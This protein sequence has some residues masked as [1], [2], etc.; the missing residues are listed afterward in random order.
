[1]S[2]EESL[3]R[4]QIVLVNSLTTRAEV[5]HTAASLRLLWCDSFSNPHHLYLIPVLTVHKLLHLFH[6]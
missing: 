1:V 4:I 6:P 2:L 5:K 3:D